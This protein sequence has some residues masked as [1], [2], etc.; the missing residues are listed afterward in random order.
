MQPFESFNFNQ[1]VKEPIKIKGHTLGLVL[2]LGLPINNLETQEMCVSDH[3]AI[4]LHTTIAAKFSEAF[5]VADNNR[6][7]VVS[8]SNTEKLL[9]NFNQTCLVILNSIS[10][11][12][13]QS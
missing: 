5:Q 4:A 7:A 12:K 13:A 11:L 10:P 2:L 1:F 6:S 3:R 8:H 9:S